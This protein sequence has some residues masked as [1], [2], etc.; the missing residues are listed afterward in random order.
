MQAF[1]LAIRELREAISGG[2]YQR[3][4]KATGQFLKSLGDLV[5]MLSGGLGAEDPK[6]C[7]E[8][9]AEIRSLEAAVKTKTLAAPPAGPLQKIDW[10]KLL[11]VVMQFLPF[12]L[13][14]LEPKPE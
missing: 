2:D 4:A 6:L 9:V 7:A 5:L 12:I 14:F 10:Q 3:I 13:A 1:L 11:G 8:C